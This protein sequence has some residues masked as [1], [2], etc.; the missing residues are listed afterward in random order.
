M[1]IMKI[2]SVVMFIIPDLL[3]QR[4]CLLSGLRAFASLLGEIESIAVLVVAR[5][6][7]GSEPRSQ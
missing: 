2:E 6:L 1:M 5:C 3:S 4:S 7:R